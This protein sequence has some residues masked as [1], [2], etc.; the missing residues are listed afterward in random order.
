MSS[1]YTLG[2]FKHD[3]VYGGD[4]QIMLSSYWDDQAK[5]TSRY[6]TQVTLAGDDCVTVGAVELGHVLCVLLQDVH[7][8]GSTLGETG[9]ADVALVRLLSWKT[10]QEN[11]FGQV[12]NN[13]VNH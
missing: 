2:K 8:H 12:H 9:V 1:V 11:T 3:E 6:L 4:V 5:S 10:K 7:L 13:Q